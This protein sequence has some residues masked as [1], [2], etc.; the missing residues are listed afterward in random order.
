MPLANL[1]IT[2][3]LASTGFEPPYD[4]APPEPAPAPAPAPAPPSQ[5]RTGLGMLVAGPLTIAVGVPFAFLG[6]KAWRDNCGPFS[7]NRECAD[8]TIASVGGHTLAGMAFATG[9]TLT[10]I[11]GSR[12]GRY[13]AGQDPS[14]EGAGF[15]AGGAVLLPVSV[16][17]LG[18]VRLF[19]WLPTPDCETYACVARS[20][21]TSSAVVA[22]LALTA[23]V[24]AGLLT[25]GVAYNRHRTRMPPVVLL[26][27]AGR[28]YAGL[29]LMGQF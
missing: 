16:I 9:I 18:M 24:G 29:N 10:A 19:M 13:D 8:G 2:A 5:Q 23:S 25:Y 15:I 6:N 12:R 3:L 11:G 21:T 4:P 14:R 26:P 1:L 17:G 27:Q 28:G 7:S 22:S 20:Q